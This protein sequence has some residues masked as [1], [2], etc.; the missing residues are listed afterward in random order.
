MGLPDKIMRLLRPA[1]GAAPYLGAALVALPIA[2]VLASL[3][4]PDEG[5]AL[6]HVWSTTGPLY[7]ANTIALAAMVAIGAG[8]IG[9]TAAALVAL[10]EF[11]GCRIFAPALALPLAV[12]AYVAAYAYGDLFGPF[13]P[14][15]GLFGEAGVL[16][17]RSLPGA[18]FVLALATYPYVYL[19]ARASFE[20][21]TASISSR[22]R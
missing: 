8:A 17:I 19:A 7:L 14:A 16:P 13:G 1:V 3:A 11:P 5:G 4:R 10:A 18:A 15:A 9:V 2:A 20:S 12:P 22:M 6:A 21:V